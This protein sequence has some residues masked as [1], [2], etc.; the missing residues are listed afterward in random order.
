MGTALR[1]LLA[2]SQA[3]VSLTALIG[4]TVLIASAANPGLQSS[5]APP[6]DYLEGSPFTDYLV[7]GLALAVFLGIG[8]AVAFILTLRRARAATLVA[9]GAGFATLIWIFVQMIYIPFSALQAIYFAVGLGQ[10]GLVLL[11]LGVFSGM[12][13]GGSVV[14]SKRSAA[15]AR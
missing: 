11:H 5:W 9:A 8:Q 4:G 12:R 13:A 3:L 1:W 6:L 15:S 7:P 14:T 2:G 10:L